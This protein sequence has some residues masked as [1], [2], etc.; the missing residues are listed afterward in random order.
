MAVM[1]KKTT[2][3]LG[4]IGLGR[5]GSNMVRR[6]IKGGVQCVVFNRSPEKVKALV[7]EKAIGASSL[8]DLVKKLQKPRAVWLMVPAAVV[9]TFIA[10][11]LPQ[12]EPGDIL[13]DDGT[14]ATWTT[15][16]ARRTSRRRTF[17]MWT[18]ERAAPACS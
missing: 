11:L 15:S 13:I 6:L 12:L 18:W 14:R 7:K 10:D 16:G 8:A 4:M 3:Q 2:T 1:K 5:M 17:T 9:D